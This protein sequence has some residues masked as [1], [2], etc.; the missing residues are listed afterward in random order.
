M[1]VPGFVYLAKFN[2]FD[3]CY[4]IGSTSDPIKRK[5]HLQSLYGSTHFIVFGEVPDKLGYERKI[6]QMLYRCSHMSII[7]ENP[8]LCNSIETLAKAM[9][10]GNFRSMEHFRFDDVEV[11]CAI[12]LFKS[13][14]TNPGSIT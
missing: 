7:A 8:E 4:K 11:K 14:C 13:V 12:A 1:G 5:N 3:G 10:S 2:L 9:P 6:Q